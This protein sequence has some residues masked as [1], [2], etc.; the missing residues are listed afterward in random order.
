LER[1]DSGRGLK[2]ADATNSVPSG[3]D[4]GDYVSLAS[5]NAFRKVRIMNPVTKPTSEAFERNRLTRRE[6]DM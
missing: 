6:T 3:R 2:Y 4:L 1:N 5:P